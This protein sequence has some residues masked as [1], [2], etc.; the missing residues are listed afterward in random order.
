MTMTTFGPLANAFAIAAVLALTT[1]AR[2]QSPPVAAATAQ[3]TPPHHA[4]AAQAPTDAQHAGMTAMREKMMA[5]MSASGVAL[6]ALVVKMKAA[7]GR[8]KVDAIAELLETMVQ[9]H[10]AMHAGMMQM[11]GPTTPKD[12]LK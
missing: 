8:A 11:P 9:Q 7:T 5:D 3:T 10:K 2:A 4:V 12:S 6:D 1:S